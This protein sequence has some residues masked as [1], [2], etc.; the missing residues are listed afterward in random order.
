MASNSTNITLE[1]AIRRAR[2]SVLI[3]ENMVTIERKR[4][5]TAENTL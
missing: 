1:E 3:D 4:I 2:I 5:A